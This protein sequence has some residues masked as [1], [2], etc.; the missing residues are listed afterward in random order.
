[1]DNSLSISC[2]VFASSSE[3][4][5]FGKIGALAVR[6]LS[7]SCKEISIIAGFNSVSEIYLK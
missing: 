6:M 5:S 4:S 1:M 7:T 2:F 3:N